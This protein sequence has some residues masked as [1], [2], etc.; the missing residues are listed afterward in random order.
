MN[1][2]HPTNADNAE[3]EGFK[4]AKDALVALEQIKDPV[5]QEYELLQYAKL[6]DLP[7]ESFRQ[8]FKDYCRQQQ[9][10]KWRQYPLT[11]LF[12]STELFLEWLNKNLSKMD[13]FPVLDYL[14]KLS[15]IL[16]LIVYITEGGEREEQKIAQQRRANYE[17][18]GVIRAGVGQANNGGRI[19]ALEHLNENQS[20]LSGINLERAILTRIKLPNAQLDSAK[21]SQVIMNR[22]KLQGAYLMN[23]DLSEANL[24]K[25]ELHEA[26][27]YQANLSKANLNEADLPKAKLIEANLR[28]ANFYKADLRKAELLDANLVEACLKDAKLDEINLEGAIYNRQTIFPKDFNPSKY[29]AILLQPG[30]NLKDKYLFRQD[31]T[32]IDLS[33]VNLQ[34]AHLREANLQGA[35]LKDTN[36]DKADLEKADLRGAKGL[37]ITQI[38]KAKNWELANY[39]SSLKQELGLVPKDK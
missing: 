21:L 16:G 15:I 5:R 32:D 39:D 37:N 10:K 35:I 27:F 8:M 36:L 28:K 20:F 9:E 2:P 33:Q 13:I 18:W 4:K 14:S 11:S 17:A 24:I 23:S 30:A 25:A 3:P 7:L 1:N 31:L 38:K 12:V 19:E 34:D 26:N 29:G 22:A 6:C